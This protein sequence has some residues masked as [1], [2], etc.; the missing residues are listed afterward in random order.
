MTSTIS[1]LERFLLRWVAKILPPVPVSKV[2][3]FMVDIL[4]HGAWCGRIRG[5]RED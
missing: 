2:I 1:I 5:E 3:I 4:Y